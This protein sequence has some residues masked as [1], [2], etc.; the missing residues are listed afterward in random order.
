MKILIFD[1]TDSGKK[2]DKALQTVA[3]YAPFPI[4]FGVVKRAST[5][6]Q[7]VPPPI[8]GNYHVDPKWFRD[9][10]SINAKGY[11]F[12][13]AYFSNKQWS[14][15]QKKNRSKAE[16][17]NQN[18]GVSEIALSGSLTKKS[19]KSLAPKIN[20]SEF[21]VR[22]LHEMCHGMFD[23]KLKVKDV[24]HYWHY[25]KKNLLEAIKLW[26]PK[27]GRTILFETALSCLGIDVTPDDIVPDEVGCADT[28][29]AIH[30]KAFGKV[31]GGGPSTYWLYDTLLKHTQFVKVDQPL[32][33][34]IVISP[35][36]YGNGN[37]S[38]GHVGIVG[39]GDLIM[40][41]DSRDGIFWTNYTL[42]SWKKRYVDKG[43]Y[44][45]D[46]FRRI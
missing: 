22:F 9:T 24:T 29:Q 15:L 35:T 43:G 33:G 2:L 11:D 36:G 39:A 4:F 30:K 28:V 42:T 23:H 19:S 44:P 10:F 16:S 20:E 34:D 5:N 38:N 46:F 21:V 13:V 1:H 37:L 32:P 25:E 7:F 27:V 26:I 6:A 14:K 45:M 8:D 12:C 3:K 31:I 18:Y 17:I 40:S 41:N